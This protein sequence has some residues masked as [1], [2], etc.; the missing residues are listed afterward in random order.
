M[1]QNNPPRRPLMR[2]VSFEEA[3]AAIARLLDIARSDTGQSQRAADFLLA[4]WNG[5]DLGHFPVLHL[6]NCDTEISEDMLVIMAYLANAGTTYANAWGHDAVMRELVM[7][8]RDIDL[9]ALVDEAHETLAAA[10]AEIRFLAGRPATD[11][12]MK[13]IRDLCGTLEH[14]PRW[15][16]PD[17]LHETGAR[18]TIRATID[19]AKA[20]IDPGKPAT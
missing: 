11:A 1:D 20:L 7:A 19:D 2:A 8:R 5:D 4:W 9:P 3:G 10:F 14:L 12:T 15:L 6:A 13:T 17:R 18:Q 16:R